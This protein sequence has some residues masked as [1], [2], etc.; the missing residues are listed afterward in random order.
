MGKGAV[1]ASLAARRAIRQP[2]DDELHLRRTKSTVRPVSFGPA[3]PLAPVDENFS[4][5]TQPS[6]ESPRER[7][8][9]IRAGRRAKD[10]MTPMHGAFSAG[11]A[12][13]AS[14]AARAAQDQYD[15]RQDSRHRSTP[16]S[17]ASAFSS[18]NAMSISRYIVAAVVRCSGGLR[19]VTGAPVERAEAEV[20]VGDE[21]AH[22]E[23][24]GERQRLLV[25][26]LGPLE[27][28][29]ASRRGDLAQKPQRLT[30]RSPARSCRRAQA[31]RR[32]AARALRGSP[33]AGM[34]LA[35]RTRPGRTIPRP[36][37]E[38]SRPRREATAPPRAAPEE[39]CHGPA[40]LW[41]S[42]SP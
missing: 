34:R 23:L 28:G 22:A 10:A 41:R 5:S 36:R 14:G 33:P 9:P 39:S 24:G 27:V 17:S 16:P 31:Q 7:R 12:S 19:V 37:P 32:V 18:Q 15:H 6:S 26:R 35:E 29:C 21:G 30:P 13:T 42:D 3:A 2:R 4:P 11:C 8:R 20:A 38:R 25:V 1:V 40:T